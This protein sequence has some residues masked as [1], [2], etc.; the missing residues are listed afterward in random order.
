[1]SVGIKRRTVSARHY[2]GSKDKTVRL[3]YAETGRELR[4]FT[5]HT[6]SVIGVALST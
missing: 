4:R 5:G 2:P 3:W 1:M 6:G